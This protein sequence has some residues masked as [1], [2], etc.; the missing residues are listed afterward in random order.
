MNLI[1]IRGLKVVY[2]YVSVPI[3]TC[4]LL[5]IMGNS[6]CSNGLLYILILSQK[7]FVKISIGH[8]VDLL[9]FFVS[10]HGF[11]FEDFEVLRDYVFRVFD[12]HYLGHVLAIRVSEKAFL[13]LRSYLGGYGRIV[14]EMPKSEGTIRSAS[15]KSRKP[16]FLLQQLALLRICQAYLKRWFQLLYVVNGTVVT[17][18]CSYHLN[19]LRVFHVPQKDHFVAVN[20]EDSVPLVVINDRNDICK[21]TRL[22][23]GHFDLL[24]ASFDIRLP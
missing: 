16:F 11:G 24:Y 23:L 10:I 14:D 3:S 13:D 19:L 17:Q 18:K 22:V 4:Y 12:K 15:N 20:G 2:S 9:S 8:V 1:Y 6:K 7:Y 5:T 21:F